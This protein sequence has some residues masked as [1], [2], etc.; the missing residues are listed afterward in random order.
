[1][2]H[3]VDHIAKRSWQILNLSNLNLNAVKYLDLHF[4]YGCEYHEKF[5]EIKI[6]R[7]IFRV[8]SKNNDTKTS[9]IE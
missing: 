5:V 3:L 7:R 4:K 6:E 9:Y 1:M 8:E 2:L